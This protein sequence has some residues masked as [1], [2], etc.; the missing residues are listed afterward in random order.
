MQ[1]VG[2]SEFPQSVVEN[3][4]GACN[5][6]CSCGVCHIHRAF[7]MN[8]ITLLPPTRNPERGKLEFSRTATDRGLTKQGVHFCEIIRGIARS[9]DVT[10]GRYRRPFTCAEGLQYRPDVLE[11]SWAGRLIRMDA[12]ACIR[13]ARARCRQQKRHEATFS[14]CATS[15]MSAELLGVFRTVVGRYRASPAA[16]LRPP[17]SPGRSYAPDWRAFARSA[18]R[19]NPSLPPN[20]IITICG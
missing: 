9:M 16:D 8:V 15:G 20:S 18:A 5:R 2:I 4:H 14:A 6:R 17:P 12:V 11:Q 19:A 7:L 10:G 3:S 1:L 13:S